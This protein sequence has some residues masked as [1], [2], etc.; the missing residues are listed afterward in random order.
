M[1]SNPW[2]W[3][4]EHRRYYRCE[5]R[6]GMNHPSYDTVSDLYNETDSIGQLVYIWD[7]T[8]SSSY[9]QPLG[10][11]DGNIAPATPT[12]NTGQ[13]SFQGTPERGWYETLDSRKLQFRCG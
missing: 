10:S 12:L 1:S 2:I 11:H 7:E 5:T 4:E 8:A 6:N 13:I 3:S 9:T